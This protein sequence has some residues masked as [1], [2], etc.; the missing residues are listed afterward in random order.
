MDFTTRVPAATSKLIRILLAEDHLINQRVML[1]MLA[2]LG[3]SADAVANGAEAVAAL[4][5]SP[6][7]IVLMD[8]QMPELD[9]YQ[10]T[11]Q[12][13]SNGGRFK[14]TPIIA[15][16]ANALEGDRE[17]CLTS[18]MSDYISKPVLPQTLA[19]TLEKW[20]MPTVESPDAAALAAP[21]PAPMPASPLANAQNEPSRPISGAA[22]YTPP[23]TRL[24]AQH[25]ASTEI[26]ADAVDAEALDALREMDASDEGFM[27]KII[28][29]F[30][31]DMVERL[32]AMKAAIDARDGGPI[33]RTAHALKGSCGHFGAT[34]LTSLC[35]NMETLAERDSMDEAAAAFV[36]LSAEA[37]RV[38]IAL[39]LA[40]TQ[41]KPHSIAAE[42]TL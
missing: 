38:R 17:K 21:T 4:N 35:R 26:E 1:R 30:L 9:G 42:A 19:T 6:Y 27:E 25:F 10:A 11:R 37:H 40:K 7:D 2:R 14:T 22:I 34:R 16:T 32:Q 8:C 36:E 3:Y 5:K 29:L 18:G 28:D 41:L 13:R 20:I 39:E 15:V 24:P 31:S 12:I 23:S 33:K